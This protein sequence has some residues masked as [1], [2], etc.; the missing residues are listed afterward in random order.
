MAQAQKGSR[1]NHKI[2]M[3][4][5]GD[6]FTGKTTLGLELAKLHDEN[7]KPMRLL[8]IDCESG[9]TSFALDELEESGVDLDNIYV[10]WTQSLAEVT[11]YIKQV[12][13][14]EPLHE[15]GPNGEELDEYVLDAD[16]EPFVPTALFLDGASILKMTCQQ[17]LLNLSRKRAKVRAKNNGLT[18]EDKAVAI[19]GAGLEYKDYNILNFSGQELILDLSASGV[20]WVVSSREKKETKSVKANGSIQAVETGN[21]IADGFKGAEYNTST[22]A[23]L[24]RDEDDPDVVKMCVLKDRSKT[25]A[26]GQVVENPTLLD[27]QAMI[28]KHNG[29]D[30]AIRNTMNQAVETEMKIY[31]QKAGITE[32]D[33]EEVQESAP[34]PA[35]SPAQPA[36][37][38]TTELKKQ[39]KSLREKMGTEMRMK[40]GERLKAEGIPTALGRID[41]SGILNRIVEICKEI[42]EG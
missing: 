7:G 35:P 3:Y 19:D 11:K 27:M 4:V 6:P 13:N 16:G 42:L 18:G 37:P 20:H 41:D 15:L 5:Y 17:S 25:W 8:V 28:D 29:R 34:A 26:V 23:R 32:L 40:L 12:T 10:V 14:R 21:L 1:F 38:S 39:I 33:E 9:G 22:L 31:Q 36:P 24:Y 2:N 30:I